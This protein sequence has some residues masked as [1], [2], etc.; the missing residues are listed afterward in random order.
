[1]MTEQKPR[2]ICIGEVV[3][4]LARGADGTFALSCGGDAFNT[5]IYLARAGIER[6]V[7]HRLGDDPYSDSAVALAA[8][9]GVSSNL[10]LRVPGRLPALCLI[11]AGTA[12]A[13]HRT[14][15]GRGRAG[16]RT[17]RTARLDAHCRKPHRGAADLFLRHHA[18]AVLEQR[19]WPAV[20]RARSGAAT[21]R[22]GGVRRQ[23]PAA[24]LERR[25]AAHPRRV[26]RSAQAGRHRAAGLR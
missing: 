13:A 14:Q 16:A 15:M 3:I 21:G 18:V 24:R 4:E 22:Q 26:P 10:M 9:E 2:A 25:P 8:A 20:R 6:G 11:E 7:R 17:V 19:A 12:G 5:A 23:F 1:M